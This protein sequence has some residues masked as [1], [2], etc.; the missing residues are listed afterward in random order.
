METLELLKETLAYYLEDPAGRRGIETRQTSKYVDGEWMIDESQPPRVNCMYAVMN[1]MTKYCA[2]GRCV[3][4]QFDGWIKDVNGS[5]E[6]LI[7]EYWRVYAFEYEQDCLDPEDRAQAEID[8]E[9]Q[10][11]E[12]FYMDEMLQEKY[13]GHSISMWLSLQEIHDSCHC[14]GE[15]KEVNMNLQE[16]LEVFANDHLSDDE[17]T[18]L[19]DWL[20]EN[21]NVSD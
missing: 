15:P 8:A 9:M 20:K 16:N 18:E 14:W 4:H 1:G 13:R 19:N 11:A 7:C 21:Y 3:D 10:E 5:V 6:D 12:E 17:K 2:V